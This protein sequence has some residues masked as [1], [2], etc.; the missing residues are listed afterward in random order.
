MTGTL[1]AFRADLRA[2]I[3][4]HVP[5]GLADTFDWRVRADLPGSVGRLQTQEELSRAQEHPLFKEW[6]QR[7]LEA[8]LVCP[9]WPEEHGGRGWNAVQ[10]TVLDEECYRA[11]VP[12]IDRIQGESM[13]GP[14]IIL[15]GT[16]EQKARFLPPII[17]GEHRYC[18]G[19][20]EPNA[21]SDLAA[22]TTR[23]VISGDDIVI[24]G[25]KLWTSRFTTANM[26][27]ILCRTDPEAPKHKGLSYVL[28]EFSPD[29]GIDVRPVRSMTGTAEFGEVFLDGVRAPLANVIGG[30]NNGW[31]VVQSTLNFERVGGGRATT[32]LRLAREREFW[33]LVD[34]VRAAGRAEDP[35]VRQQ[36][37]WAYSQ[38]EILR[39]T[40]LRI[41]ADLEAG[42]EPGP[43]AATWKLG[44]SEYHARLGGVAATLAGADSL[45]RP[46]GE[47]YPT[48]RW[49][50][51]LLTAP[52]GR[53]YAGTSE[54]QRNII[55]ERTLGLPR[56]PR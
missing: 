31:Q 37:A 23:G 8:R 13:V 52:S 47:D 48:T 39:F 35:V 11:G 50:D 51:V 27:F 38:V 53:I 18:Q 21:G 55:G 44:W 33:A 1:D 3:D 56:E 36:L 29:N 16:D 12:R 4:K 34:T 20:S 28:A 9:A 40:W 15:H 6:E 17:S 54:I 14:S 26:I 10:L 7:C 5:E 45:I 2:W 42:R 24:N 49:Q 22:V 46:D 30:L 41:L 19:F 43:E 32:L 25:Q